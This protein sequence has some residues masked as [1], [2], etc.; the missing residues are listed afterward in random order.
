MAI[1]HRLDASERDLC[2]RLRPESPRPS[3]SYLMWGLR[4]L[5]C[6]LYGPGQISW[7]R[8]LRFAISPPSKPDW[9]RYGRRRAT[10]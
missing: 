6:V 8:R 7:E 10:C 4:W 3:S 2:R 9:P 1:A 5:S